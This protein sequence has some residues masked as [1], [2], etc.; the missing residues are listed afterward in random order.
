[1]KEFPLSPIFLILISEIEKIIFQKNRTYL[2]TLTYLLILYSFST[3]FFFTITYNLVFVF[4]S[5]VFKKK[6]NVQPLYRDLIGYLVVNRSSVF[7]LNRSQFYT[8]PIIELFL[9]FLYV[10]FCV[11]S[12]SVFLV[13]LSVYLV[14]RYTVKRTSWVS[15]LHLVDFGPLYRYGGTSRGFIHHFW[16]FRF[17]LSFFV[18]EFLLITLT[19]FI[20]RKH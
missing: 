10:N 16:T 7:S 8:F 4:P 15:F 9:L 18:I 6:F 11:K 1:M 2:N 14:E 19:I 13:K 12:F 5:K 3:S 17:T 20:K